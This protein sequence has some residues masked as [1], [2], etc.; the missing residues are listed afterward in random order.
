[1]PRRPPLIIAGIPLFLLG[2][3]VGREANKAGEGLVRI[4]IR[5]MKGHLFDI[6]VHT[7]SMCRRVFQYRPRL[8]G[9]DTE[10]GGLRHHAVVADP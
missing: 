6:S 8:P 3:V 10:L 5:E 9:M 1:M 2:P 7:R 4:V